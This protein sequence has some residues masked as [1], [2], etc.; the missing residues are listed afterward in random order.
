MKVYLAGNFHT[1]WRSRIKKHFTDIEW[2]EPLGTGPDPG[3]PKWYL[4]RDLTL[5]KQAD[6]VF[7]YITDHSPV[8][9]GTSAEMGY[10]YASGIPILFVRGSK[11][12]RYDFVQGMALSTFESLEDGIEALKFV[13]R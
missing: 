6:L 7:V 12:T 11:A 1:D 10:A 13:N 3:R 2:L 5:L 8:N 9:S 4:L